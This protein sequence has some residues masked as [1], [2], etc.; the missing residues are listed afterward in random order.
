[1][2]LPLEAFSVDTV[3]GISSRLIRAITA[4]IVKTIEQPR[5]RFG[6]SIIPLKIIPDIENIR[7]KGK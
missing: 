2:F 7:I 1:M 5:I 6:I 4:P 3:N